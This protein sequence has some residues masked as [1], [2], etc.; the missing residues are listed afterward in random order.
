MKHWHSFVAAALLL[1]LPST[2]SAQQDD[3]DIR[4]LSVGMH[5][6]DMP[7]D[8]YVNFACG[9]NGGPPLR[10]L[11]SW[12]DFVLCQ[13]DDDQLHEVY[14]EYDDETLHVAELYRQ[15]YGQAL[16]LEKYAGTRVAGYPV[17]LSVLF[18]VEGVAQGLRVVTDSRAP[19]DQRVRAHALRM[20]IKPRYR[21]VE[22]N[23]VDLPLADGETPIGS[24]FIKEQCETT[25]AA[26]RRIIV[27]SNQFRKPGQTGYDNLGRYIE[28]DYESSTRWEIWGGSIPID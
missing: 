7:G 12:R 13:A 5:V 4:D 15:M 2:G 17:I 27:R 25:D 28:G 10:P 14:V 21:G 8:G 23:C 11:D 16:W 1:G 9:S 18:D 24:R 20:R 3:G 26:G 6:S 22:W 19:L